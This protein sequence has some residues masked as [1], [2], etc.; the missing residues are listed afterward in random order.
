MLNNKI[1]SANP[2]LRNT[3]MIEALLNVIYTFY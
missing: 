3:D 2:L 1:D